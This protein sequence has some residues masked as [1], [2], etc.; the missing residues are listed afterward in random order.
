MC[1]LLWTSKIWDTEDTRRLTC[2][3][4][5]LSLLVSRQEQALRRARRKRQLW[6]L[7]QVWMPWIEHTN[8]QRLQDTQLTAA[9]QMS[10][11]AAVLRRVFHRM[12]QRRRAHIEECQA[13]EYLKWYRANFQK[14]LFRYWRSSTGRNSVEWRKRVLSKVFLQAVPLPAHNSASQQEK[15]QRAI[16]AYHR[17]RVC[18][19]HQMAPRRVVRV[20]QYWNCCWCYRRD[21]FD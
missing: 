6:L 7:R 15:L 17:V 2:S 10:L 11:S 21:C 16:Q 9:V 20:T 1:C 4:R 3:V 14:R 13:D 8:Q 5:T 19:D 18:H 12:E